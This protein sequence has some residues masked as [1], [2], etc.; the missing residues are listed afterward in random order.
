M[1]IKND[2]NAKRAAVAFD[3]IV[4]LASVRLLC[5]DDHKKSL[6]VRSLAKYESVERGPGIE[7]NR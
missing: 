7:P 3:N 5:C 6:Q 2:N 1:V 4:D